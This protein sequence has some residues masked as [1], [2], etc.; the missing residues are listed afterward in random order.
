MSTSF[1]KA[2]LSDDPTQLAICTPSRAY[3]LKHNIK[4]YMQT[5]PKP[6]IFESKT[7]RKQLKIMM[8]ERWHKKMLKGKL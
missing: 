6:R 2:H 7:W 1:D 8:I 4:R 3:I 5:R